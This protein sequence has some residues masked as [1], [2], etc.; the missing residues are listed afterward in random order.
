MSGQL[1]RF[2]FDQTIYAMLGW[3]T[4]FQSADFAWK[5]QTDFVTQSIYRDGIGGMLDNDFVKLESS[6]W[7]WPLESIALLFLVLCLG[8]PVVAF[9]M[10]RYGAWLRRGWLF[11]LSPVL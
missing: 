3:F 6:Y 5:L 7:G 8:A 2:A 11:L 1:C 10:Y 9:L 4:L